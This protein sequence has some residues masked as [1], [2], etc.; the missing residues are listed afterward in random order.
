[1]P[2][3]IRHRSSTNPVELFSFMVWPIRASDWSIQNNTDWKPL[4]GQLI[5]KGALMTPTSRQLVV[6]GRVVRLSRGTGCFC[7]GGLSPQP[8]CGGASQTLSE[9]LSLGCRSRTVDSSMSEKMLGL[10]SFFHRR[11]DYAEPPACI[12]LKKTNSGLRNKGLIGF[13]NV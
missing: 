12:K 9:P 11:A 7:L 6:P 3:S 10:L 13:N 8:F 5:V 4:T 1:M 2:L